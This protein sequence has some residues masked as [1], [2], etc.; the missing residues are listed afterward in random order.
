MSL[1]EGEMCEPLS[2]GIHA[3]RR[4]NV[5]PGTNVLVVGAGPIGLVTKL[6]AQAF[7]EPRIVIEDV[8]NHRLSVVKDLSADD[9]VKVSTDMKDVPEVVALIRKG[10]G[11]DIDVRLDCAGFDKTM[12]TALNATR[13]G[14]KV[15]LL[16]MGHTK[17]T[18]LLTPAAARCPSPLLS[19]KC[20][21]NVLCKC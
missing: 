6:A 4:A 11:M 21:C 3:C 2:V 17:M 18:V 20:H 12:S 13:S 14:G 7:G 15:C 10:M 5:V 1:E 8:D 9:I 19:Y 16:G